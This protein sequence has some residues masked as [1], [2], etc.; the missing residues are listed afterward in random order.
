MIVYSATK[1]EFNNDVINNMIADKILNQFKNK[2]GRSTS[3]SEIDSWKK[4]Y[5]VHEQYSV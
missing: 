3:K 2:L 5:V 4:L 1:S